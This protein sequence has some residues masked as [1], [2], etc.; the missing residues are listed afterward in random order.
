MP[1]RA[2]TNGTVAF[3]DKYEEDEVHREVGEHSLTNLLK[4]IA[5]RRFRTEF[6]KEHETLSE[7]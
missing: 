5:P 6:N 7:S 1:E 3:G 2:L 4:C